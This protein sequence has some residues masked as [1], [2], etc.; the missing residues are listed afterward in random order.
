MK[1]RFKRN[2]KSITAL[3]L[4]FICTFLL[5]PISASAF[6][7]D[8]NIAL[9]DEVKQEPKKD[10]KNKG[11]NSK[12]NESKTEEK[13]KE[14]GSSSESNKSSSKPEKTNE[15]SNAESNEIEARSALLMEPCTG[16][17]IYEKNADEKFAPASVT[18]IMTMLLTIEAVDSGKIALDDKVTCSENAKKM[19]GSTML[20][21]TGEIRTVEELLKGV[22]IAS[23]NDAA[24]A[25]AE[26]LGG[27]ENDFV[28]MM[29]KR[30][31]ELGMTNTTFK[32]CNGLPA[33]GHLSTANDI[34]KMS[35]ELLKHPT[36]LKYTGTYMDTITEGRK[37]P[38][39]LVNHNKLVRFFD[40]CDGLKT[41]FTNEAKYCISATATRNGVRMLSVIMGAPTYK[42][43]NRDAS[44]LLNYGFSKYEGKKIFSKDEEVDK[45]YMDEQTD[46][47]FMAKAQD[48]LTAVLPK[49]CKDEV[50]KKVVIDE[51]QKE[52]KEGDV[53][54]K[55]E[56]YLNNEKIGEVTIYCDRN[57]K[58][59]NI[60][61][62]IKYN[63][64]HLF[65][66]KEEG[67][68]EKK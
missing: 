21:D 40:G 23:G 57:I 35:K 52:Y 51:L 64:T 4:I 36:I 62:N 11:E 58:K 38:I 25:L 44:I 43:R 46:R 12:Q 34:A 56:I 33:D 16:K 28:G 67:N 18:K 53:V 68:E 31:E 63:I 42:I 20:L 55:C 66:D 22:A 10:D 29:N 17:I 15:N 32:N 61:D 59:G 45:V 47:Y 60:F 50:E 3:T 48:D 39:E 7:S 27:T 65:G 19:G 13:S 8:L 54:G 41:G 1:R 5:I 37:S 26:Y 9:E 14:K 6:D 24:V 49:G 2:L 30:A